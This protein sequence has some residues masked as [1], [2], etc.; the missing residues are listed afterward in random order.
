METFKEK[1]RY[2]DDEG[3]GGDEEEACRKII[4]TEQKTV[5]GVGECSGRDSCML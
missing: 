2:C 4:S 1:F 5:Q 3:N